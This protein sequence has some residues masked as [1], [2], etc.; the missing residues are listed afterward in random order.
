MSGF[1]Y[2]SNIHPYTECLKRQQTLEDYA[3]STDLDLLIEARYDLEDFLRQAVFR[4]ADRCRACYHARLQAT[5]RL[6]KQGGFEGF[7]STLL[8]SRFQQHA[9]IRSMGEAAGRSEGVPFLYQ[10]FRTGWQ[11]GVR[12]SKAL[13]M[14]RQQ[15]CGCIYSEKERYLPHG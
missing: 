5:A 10:D 11:E 13:G 7:S 1:Y 4:E 14:Y 15:Y 3:R 6:A 9:L 12:A 8:Y 2:R